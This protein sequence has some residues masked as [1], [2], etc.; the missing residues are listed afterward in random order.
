VLG[1]DGAV[2]ARSDEVIATAQRAIDNCRSVGVGLGPCTLPAAGKPNFEI[3]A[4]TMEGGI[5]HPGLQGRERV[6]RGLA[7]TQLNRLGQPLELTGE[8]QRFVAHPGMNRHHQR[9][10]RCACHQPG[11]IRRNS[12]HAQLT[13]K[14]SAIHPIR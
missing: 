7:L 9:L 4:G 13:H 3:T 6:A 2:F 10:R 11:Q 12:K 1:L 8:I 14:S 5:G